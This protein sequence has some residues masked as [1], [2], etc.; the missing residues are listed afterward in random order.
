MRAR[1]KQFLIISI[2]TRLPHWWAGGDTDEVRVAWK[3]TNPKSGAPVSCFI[4][5]WDNPH[6]ERKIAS[7][8]LD[9]DLVVLLGVTL[10]R[11]N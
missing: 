2:P 3:G 4:Q 6:P 1:K 8:S 9:G 10:E 7:M 11:T 5:P